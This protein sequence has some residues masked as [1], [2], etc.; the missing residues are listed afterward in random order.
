V[1]NSFNPTEIPLPDDAG[2]TDE[3]EV[4]SDHEIGHICDPGVEVEKE[5]I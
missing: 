3:G 1:G 5:S 2:L 4:R